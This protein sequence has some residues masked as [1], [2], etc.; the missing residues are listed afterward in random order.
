M[1][2]R[3]FGRVVLSDPAAVEPG[4]PIAKGMKFVVGYDPAAVRH[5]ARARGAPHLMRVC[6]PLRAVEPDLLVWCS[7]GSILATPGDVL[8]V[9]GPPTPACGNP[10]TARVGWPPEVGRFDLVNSAEPV[11]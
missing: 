1:P 3:Q 9:L 7:V 11:I 4:A 6:T 2:R 8:A 5:C 10:A